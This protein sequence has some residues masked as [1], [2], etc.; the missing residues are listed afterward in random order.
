M[1]ASRRAQIKWKILTGTYILQANRATFNQYSVNPTCEQV[2]HARVNKSSF[3]RRAQ[4]LV[5]FSLLS[6][7]L[8][9]HECNLL[10]F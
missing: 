6:P 4:E 9:N 8:A 3:H 5:F 10:P 2:A 7:F 1:I